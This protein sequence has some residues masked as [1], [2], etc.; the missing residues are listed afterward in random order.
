MKKVTIKQLIIQDFKGIKSLE[1]NFNE[2]ETTIKGENGTGKSTVFDAFMWLLFGK[3]AKDRKDYEIKRIVNGVP[4]EKTD[5]RVI[6]LLDV[7]GTEVVLERA[8]VEDWVKPRGATEQVF[9]GNHTEYFYN[10]VPL[11]MS[12]Y[13]ERVADI[14]DDTVFKLITNAA[15]FTNMKWQEQREQLFALAGTITDAEV[16]TLDKKYAELLD[17]ISGKSLLDYKREIA[18]KKRKL[19]EELT[20]LQPRIDQTVKMMPEAENWDELETTL[21]GIDKEIELTEQALSDKSEAAKQMYERQEAMQRQI[22]ALKTEK[23]EREQHWADA[24]RKSVYEANAERR[25]IE[26]EIAELEQEMKSVDRR[27]HLAER[28]LTDHTRLT[29]EKYAEMEALRDKWFEVNSST[30]QGEDTCRCCGQKLP[31][32]MIAQAKAL[33]EKNKAEELDKINS[34]GKALKNIVRDLQQDRDDKE[35]EVFTLRE[36]SEKLEYQIRAKQK[37]LQARTFIREEDARVENDP[38]IDALDQQIAELEQSL[39]N[40]KNNTDNSHDNTALKEKKEALRQERDRLKERISKRGI[41]AKLNEEIERIS[42]HAK[43]MSQQIASLEKDEDTANDFTRRKI[44]ESEKRINSLFKHV[45]F[46]LYDYTNDGNEFETCVPLVDGIPY[47]SAN[48]AG[49]INAGID[50]INTL[51]KFYNVRAPIFIDNRESINNIIDTES[52]I[53]NLVVSKDKKLQII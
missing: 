44:E 50:I 43:E 49:Q 40:H 13:N 18:S 3:D 47:P 7:D 14:I 1:V 2:K 8:F 38:K 52:Q 10:S 11:K 25:S 23:H 15:Y 36:K 9:K 27:F 42:A 53:I 26:A 17:R 45:T 19:R 28:E 22:H 35:N 46:R 29:D 34:T 39:S 33:F 5:A 37:D 32:E 4:L 51:T 12:E 30:Y 16:A 20:Q 41:I 31:D 6:G 48:T 24:V 21:S